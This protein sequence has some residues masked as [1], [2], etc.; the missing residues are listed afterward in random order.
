[1]TFIGRATLLAFF[2]SLGALVGAATVSVLMF[3]TG[4]QEDAPKI[5]ATSAW[6]SGVMDAFF[7]AGH[8]VSNADTKRLNAPGLPSSSVG[9]VEARE[10]GADF[11]VYISL[12]YGPSAEAIGKVRIAPRAVSYRLCNERGESLFQAEKKPNATKSGAEDAQNAQEIARTLIVQMKK[13]R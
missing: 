5:E 10:G 6:E 8:I 9:L 13:G 7:N 4:V 1:M 12:D 11:V 3:E 2:V